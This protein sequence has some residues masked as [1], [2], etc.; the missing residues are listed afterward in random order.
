MRVVRR[1]RPHP[2]EVNLFSQEHINGGAHYLA[3]GKEALY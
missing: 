1:M 3:N 2:T